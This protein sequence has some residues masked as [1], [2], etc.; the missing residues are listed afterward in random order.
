MK[1]SLRFKRDTRIKLQWGVGKKVFGR[2]PIWVIWLIEL[3]LGVIQT[4]Q[5][6]R[7]KLLIAPSPVMNSIRMRNSSVHWRKFSAVCTFILSAFYSTAQTGMLEGIIQYE[8]HIGRY[9]IAAILEQDGDSIHGV[10]LYQSKNIPI[11]L[12]G[13][14]SGDGQWTLSEFS[15]DWTLTESD[16]GWSGSWRKKGG[17]GLSLE[18]ISVGSAFG[19]EESIQRWDWFGHGYEEWSDGRDWGREFKGFQVLGDWVYV[20][21][22]I[23]YCF[24]FDSKYGCVSNDFYSWD[25]G[26]KGPFSLEEVMKTSELT[27]WKQ[28]LSQVRE[29]EYWRAMVDFADCGSEYN[30]NFVE[31]EEVNLNTLDLSIEEKFVS[32]SGRLGF[33]NYCTAGNYWSV[34]VSRKM[35]VNA[36]ISGD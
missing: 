8:G 20:E 25:H 32:L 1:S 28:F 21:G 7:S 19:S 35:F 4:R 27:W 10:Y 26:P 36:L 9:P 3:L 13:V 24:G 23:G 33:A 2:L 11:E 29:V 14:Y 31:N 34:E 5:H 18:L 17:Q 6:V 15:G 30:L 16:G 12:H 22:Y